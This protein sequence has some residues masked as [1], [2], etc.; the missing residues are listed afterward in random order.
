MNFIW[1]VEIRR[2]LSAHKISG[3]YRSISPYDDVMHL[4]VHDN[5]LRSKCPGRLTVLQITS[6]EIG[7]S[8]AY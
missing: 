2:S 4:G 3:D 8:A 6:R 1:H 5:M 7:D